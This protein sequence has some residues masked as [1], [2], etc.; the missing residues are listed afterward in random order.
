MSLHGPHR[1]KQGN[2]ALR[3]LA[4]RPEVWALEGRLSP[5]QTGFSGALALSLLGPALASLQLDALTS[6]VAVASSAPAPSGTASR[7][8]AADVSVRP[9]PVSLLRPVAATPAPASD[10]SQTPTA[11]DV[12][13]PAG[14]RVGSGSH[15]LD[16][17]AQAAQQ[18]ANSQRARAVDGA[19]LHRASAGA[20]WSTAPDRAG[21]GSV[22]GN[23]T[24]FVPPDG[25]A[26]TK[27]TVVGAAV[28]T[29]S[30][31]L[32]GN[33]LGKIQSE[34][35]ITW[36]SH[37]V[38]TAFNDSRGVNCP[39]SGYGITGW[40]FS[41]DRGR[42]FQNGG[43]LPGGTGFAHGGDPWLTTG[44]DGTIYLADLCN[45]Y[46]SI[47][48]VRGTVTDTG[49]NWAGPATF[50]TSTGPDKEA[51][52]VDPS[53][54][55]IY[56][57]YTRFGGGSG[58]W[59]FKSTDG[60]VSFTGPTAVTTA[61]NTQGSQPVVGPNGQLYVTWQVNSGG[62]SNPTGIGFARSTDGGQTFQVF[63]SVAPNTGGAVPSGM[64]RSPQF[65]HIAVDRSGGATNGNLYITY[66]SSALG[67]G[68]GLDALIIR[69][70]DGGTTWS[71]PTRINDD[72]TAA[73]QWYPTINVDSVGYLH[74]FFYDRR[75]NSGN[76]TDIYYARSTNGGLSWE[77]N[78]RVTPQS[79]NM[80]I[81]NN[82]GFST[83]WGDYM[84]ADTEGKGAMVAFAG[85]A[86]GNPDAFFVR[87]GN[88]D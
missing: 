27:N 30:S 66:H 43:V 75:V 18:T 82:E 23:P 28:Q 54:G 58:I 32:C 79:F 10:D 8:V 33:G 48:V 78:V 53:N 6:D 52:A 77:P 46:N 63:T 47:C 57:T 24:P 51:I 36:S 59:L 31:T 61:S 50:G 3:A 84:N 76:L 65:P 40:A 67:G 1:S 45:S 42:S 5:G 64:E 22:S 4:C 38:V 34:T 88:R 74:S 16:L 37:A 13:P 70:T 85:G 12:A 29:N 25:G 56:L 39:S 14:A 68:T 17:G 11:A 69:S 55:T 80:S 81:L 83:T 20:T 7:A 15:A 21:S 26:G 19:P 87:V 44:P 71:A 9:A 41:V 73:N 35:A 62:Y 2:A 72:G 49:I 86:N 60:G